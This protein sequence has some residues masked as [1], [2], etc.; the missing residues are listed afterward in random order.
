MC[1]ADDRFYRSPNR[2]H[3]RRFF[4]KYVS[5]GVAN[6]VLKTG[7]LRWSSPLRFNDPF[8]VTQEL[9]LNFDEAELKMAV[10]LE[11][12][13][14]IEEGDPSFVAGHP[15]VELLLRT[16]NSLPDPSMRQRVVAGLRR[17]PGVTTAGQIEAF[18]E[19][20]QTWRD[21]VPMFRVLCLSELKDV[22]SMWHHYADSY[23]GAVLEFEAVDQL[24]SVFLVARPVTYQ[25]NP[26]AI[27]SKQAWARCLLG[28]G[29]TT[30]KDLF[31]EYQYVKTTAWAYEREWRIVTLERPG[32]SGL[33]ADYPFYPRELTG[34][35]LG[36]RCSEEDEAGIL[37][38]L[39]HGFEHVSAYRARSNGTGA[40]F[41]FHEI[42]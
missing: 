12:A 9:R 31:T 42:R 2:C 15:G 1:E 11:L 8:D 37:S 32:E 3:D 18:A 28:R 16:L 29:Q 22:T 4:Y 39:T 20:K 19:L 30:Y 25:D 27:A 35:Y 23:R 17:D 36:V 5:A 7:T 10:A 41:T 24:D 26:P 13:S 38:L 14:L 33:F 34:V 40:K 21:L 6:T